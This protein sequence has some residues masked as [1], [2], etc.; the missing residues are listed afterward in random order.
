MF[1][2]IALC[3]LKNVGGGEYDTIRHLSK[4]LM[5]SFKMM[6]ILGW[7]CAM[8]TV[9]ELCSFPSRSQAKLCR[10]SVSNYNV[11]YDSPPP[12]GCACGDT[13]PLPRRLWLS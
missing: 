7:Q 8:L 3:M 11:N 9:T 12:L 5:H 4:R 1:Q 13:T 10:F 6:D 2:Y